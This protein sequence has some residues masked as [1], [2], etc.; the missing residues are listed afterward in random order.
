MIWFDRLGGL[1]SAVCSLHCTA[2]VSLP[3]VASLLG[4]ELNERF[5][6]GFFAIAG[7]LALL[8]AGA[9]F[10]R[11]RSWLLLSGFGVGLLGLGVGRAAEAWSLFEGGG[12][13]TI[14]G[15]LILVASHVLSL[16]SLRMQE[17]CCAVERA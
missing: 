9:G 12:Q 8:A 1:A 13:V 7:F 6:W 15:G 3:A 17:D 14:A 10:R 4:P 16:R 5:E 2:I 11:H